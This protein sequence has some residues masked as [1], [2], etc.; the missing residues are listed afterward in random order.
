VSGRRRAGRQASHKEAHGPPNSS[1]GG[2]FCRLAGSTAPLGPCLPPTNPLPQPTPPP[3]P[4]NPPTPQPHPPPQLRRRGALRLF[5]QGR[6]RVPAA[7]G[8]P[9]RRAALPRLADRAR[10]QGGGG[11]GGTRGRGARGA[12]EAWRK[13]CHCAPALAAARALVS[14]LCAAAC[15]PPSIPDRSPCLLRPLSLPPPKA[16]W[17][18][19]HPFGLWKPKVGGKAGQRLEAAP[20]TGARRGRGLPASPTPPAPPPTRHSATPPHPHPPPPNPQPPRSCSPS[21]T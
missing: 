4:P 12:R 3:L 15:S 16:Y 11:V 20:G 17:E 13:P 8:A 10:G 1:A 6:P 18:D 2:L 21:T 14:R 19:Y 9:A 7:D 5:L